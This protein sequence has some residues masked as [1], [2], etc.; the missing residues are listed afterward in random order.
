METVIDQALRDVLDGNAARLFQRTQIENAFVRNQT[1]RAAVQHG[2]MRREALGH[3]VR[4]EDC[5]FGRGRQTLRAHH[6]DIHP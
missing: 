6:G 2:V 5:A 4:G 3:I 1:A